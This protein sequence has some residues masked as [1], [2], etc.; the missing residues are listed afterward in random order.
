MQLTQNIVC[1]HRNTHNTLTVKKQCH[2]KTGEKFD[3]DISSPWPWSWDPGP[4][5]W[6]RAPSPC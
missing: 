5:P 1:E 6:P 2:K 3:L 4:W